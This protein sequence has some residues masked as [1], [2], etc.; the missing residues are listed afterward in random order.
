MPSRSTLALT[1]AFV[2]C[3]LLSACGGSPTTPPPPPPP[4]PP[5]ANALPSIDG[6]AV[7][8]RRSGQPARVADVR[9]TVDVVATVSDAET[10]IDQLVY[11]WSA[12]A[13]TFSGTGRAV[14]WTAPETAATPGIVTLTLRVRENYGHPGQAQIYSHEVSGTQTLALHDSPA[15]I[16]GMVV[17]FLTEFSKPQTNQDWQDIMMDFKAAA[18]PRPSEVELEREDVI[19]HYENVVMHRFE[20]GAPAVSVTFGGACAFRSLNLVGDA[21][22]ITPVDW[23]ST[24]RRFGHAPTQGRSHISAAYSTVDSRW[25]LCGSHY[26]PTDTL[27]HPFYSR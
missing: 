22:A 19:D 7:Q 8:G 17:R 2:S 15:E 27:S 21:C 16:G 11:Q 18:C 25:W 6:I 10:P 9:E 5:P 24:D 13:G 23:D 12:T 1:L 26:E 3:T 20:I 14:T 4:V